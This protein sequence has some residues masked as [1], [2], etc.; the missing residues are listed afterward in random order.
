MNQLGRKVV[1][2]KGRRRER[3]CRELTPSDSVYVDVRVIL[4]ICCWI[5]APGKM[6]L[7]ILAEVF[8]VWLP[9]QW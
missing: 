8:G 4:L 9:D 3:P 5:S 1:W 7:V 2:K 6:M